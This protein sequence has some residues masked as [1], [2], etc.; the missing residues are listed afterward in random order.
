M[1]LWACYKEKISLKNI[2]GIFKINEERSL[3]RSWIRIR[4]KLSRIPNIALNTGTA[5]AVIA[6][7]IIQ[8]LFVPMLGLEMRTPYMSLSDL[9]IFSIMY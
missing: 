2:L 8:A 4:T 6:T 9:R 1:C 7:E 3:I 5:F